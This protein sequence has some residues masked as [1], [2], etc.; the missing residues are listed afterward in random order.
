[1]ISASRTLF[2]SLIVWAALRSASAESPEEMFA[3]GNAAY[4]G[5]R[6]EEAAEAYR[7]VLNYGFQD[8]RV[9]Y[10]LG[11]AAFKLGRLG[12][13]VLHYERALRLEPTDED[14]LGNLALAR[15]RCADKVEMPETAAPVRIVRSI[16]DRLGPDRQA[17][18]LL[19]VVWLLAALVA[20]CA[21]RPGGWNVTAGWLLSVLLFLTVIVTASWYATSVRL[22][23]TRLAVVL[24]AAV[25]VLAGP[26]QNNA[27]IFTIHE[28]LTIEVVSERPEWVQVSLPNG[29]NGWVPRDALGIV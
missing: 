12:E 20:W 22:E 5:G 14:A 18:A 21:A 29:L 25:D 13:S 24:Q 27:S 16:Q 23:R 17:V 15:M 11:N 7:T 4:E 9:E 26:D 19:I 3:R 1:M 6:Y 10:N 28:G 8:P 2:P